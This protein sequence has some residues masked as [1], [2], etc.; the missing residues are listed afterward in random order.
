MNFRAFL[1]NLL[2]SELFMS[3]IAKR[4]VVRILAT[5]KVSITVLFGDKA[6]RF[7]PRTGMRTV[8]K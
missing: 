6:F 7:E 3:A 2:R 1:P 8:T 5:A 4:K